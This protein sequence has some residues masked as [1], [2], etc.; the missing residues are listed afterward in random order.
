VYVW[1]SSVG[2]GRVQSG[3]IY[4]GCHMDVNRLVSR[5]IQVEAGSCDKQWTEISLFIMNR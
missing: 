3:E 2:T 4:L 5:C 1:T